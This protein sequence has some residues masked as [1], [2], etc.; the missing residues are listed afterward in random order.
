MLSVSSYGISA[1]DYYH[2]AAQNY[3]HGNDQAAKTI[4]SEGLQKFPHDP[5]LTALNALIKDPEKQDKD[6]SQKPNQDNNKQDKQDGD[7]QNRNEQNDKEP[8][9][10]RPQEKKEDMKKKEAERIIMQFADDA[11]SL[12]KPPKKKGYGL[13]Q[14]KPEKD[15]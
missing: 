12:N 3:I 10:P 5:S 9:R 13:L 15:W 4:I 11:D 1:D 14:R 6:S 2:P 7:Q 8:P